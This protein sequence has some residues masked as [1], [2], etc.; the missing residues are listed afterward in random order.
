MPKIYGNLHRPKRDWSWVRRAARLVGYSAIAFA[1]AYGLFFGPIFRV[2]TVDIQGAH[3]SDSAVIQKAVPIGASIWTLPTAQIVAAVSADPLVEHVSVGRGIPNVA[4]IVI[5][6]RTPA[7]LWTS[8][9]SAYLVDADGIA[10]RR[11]DVSALPDPSSSVGKAM[12]GLGHVTDTTGVPVTLG[13]PVIGTTLL[14]FFGA[15]QAGFA[16]SLP[17]LHVDHAEVGETTY[18]LTVVT[19]EGMTVT[20]NVLGDSGVQMRNLAR[21]VN[22][23]KVDVTKAHV[24]LRIDRWAYVS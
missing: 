23:S 16:E 17:A 4:R 10:F 15:V 11:Y 1:V 7:L 5:T 18:D 14:R 20:F 19:K 22:Q 3:F 13:Q 9:S 8:G 21:L 24:D 12:A 6:E 2:S